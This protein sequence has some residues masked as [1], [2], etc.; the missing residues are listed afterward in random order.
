MCPPAQSNGRGAQ[1]IM[2]KILSGDI[3]YKSTGM[4][5]FAWTPAAG[6]FLFDTKCLHT[7]QEYRAWGTSKRTGKRVARSLDSVT[8]D[9]VRRAEYMATGILNYCIENQAQAMVCELPNGGAQNAAAAKSMGAAVS[10]ISVVRLVLQIPAEWVTP[11]QSRSA[12]GWNKQEHPIEKG[13]TEAEHRRAL[14]DRKRDLKKHVMAVM[15]AK[16][17]AI[18]DL[19][20]VNREHI[21]DACAAFEAAR[22]CELL[23]QLIEGRKEEGKT[24][25][26]YPKAAP[27]GPAHT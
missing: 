24:T 17:P 20:D 13:L 23:Q 7:E 6:W 14:Q 25:W 19:A 1:L 9:D 16:Y 18:A 2:I 11:D 22:N 12:A 10:L 3:G 27:A 21:A 4:A 8:N 5:I 15:S 26:I